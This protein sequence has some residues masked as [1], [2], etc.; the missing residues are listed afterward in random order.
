MKSCYVEVTYRPGGPLAAYH[1]LSREADENSARN[2]RVEP[3]LVTDYSAE[4][5]PLGIEITAPSHIPVTAI[6]EVR[7]GLG[8]PA[9]S[10]ADLAPLLAA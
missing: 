5:R 7:Q 9:V 8:Y 3:G 4:E 1:Y 10:R 6:N 2:G